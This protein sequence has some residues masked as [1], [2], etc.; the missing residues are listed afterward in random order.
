[1]KELLKIPLGNTI[2]YLKLSKKIG[3]IKAIRAVA[4]AN[5]KYPLSIIISCHR[6]IGSDVSLT[7]YD[8]G[9]HRKKWLLDLENPVKQAS[10]F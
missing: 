6:V 9:L 4:N 10:L 2:S 7:G 1:L 3:D 8:G 5:G